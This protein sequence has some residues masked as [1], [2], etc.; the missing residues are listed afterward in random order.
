MK[1]CYYYL[2]LHELLEINIDKNE[3]EEIISFVRSLMTNKGFF[4]NTV[5][6]ERRESTEYLIDPYYL[7]TLIYGHK[8][9]SIYNNDIN[10]I[11]LQE[12]FLKCINFN[13]YSTE[14][15]A[16]ISTYVEISTLYDYDNSRYMEEIESFLLNYIKNGL[17][18][19]IGYIYDTFVIA[20]Y[21]N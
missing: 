9:I 5:K 12:E 15:C 6:D 7:E 19:N 17:Q 20:K 18:E 3:L 8:L 11:K 4:Y 16:L 21:I 2:G 10:N 14:M 1:N 13:D